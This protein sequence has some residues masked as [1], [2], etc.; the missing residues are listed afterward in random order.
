[1]L[2]LIQRHGLLIVFAN[3]LAEQLGLPIPAVPTLVIAG[4]LVWDHSLSAPAVF[5]CAFAA[6]TLGNVAWYAAGRWQGR[7]V[8]RLL[9]IVSIS[10]DSCV[11]QMETRFTRW[12]S[13]ALVAAYFIPGLSTVARPLAGA[14]GVGWGKFLLMNSL[15]I[16]VWALPCIGLGWLFHDQVNELLDMLVA[17]GRRSVE[18]ILIL[19]LAYLAWR[20][21]QRH[22]FMKRL[23]VA[24]ITVNELNS[25]IGAGERPV[26]VDLRSPI[27]RDEEP[28]LIP[29]ARVM[30]LTEVGTRTEPLPMDREIIFYCTC[31]NEASAAEA[32]RRLMGLGYVRVRPLLGGMDAWLE[33]GYEIVEWQPEPDV[34]TDPDNLGPAL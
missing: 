24:R 15:G 4:A 18:V 25:L 3:V 34:P 7:K 2:E 6:A 14:T 27:A 30:E 33:A 21:W 32:A 19:L 8:M 26:I 13:F 5:A 29:G 16:V 31:P 23:R 10:P 11:R 9:C 17:Y 20:W 28:R 12:G 22:T 1:M